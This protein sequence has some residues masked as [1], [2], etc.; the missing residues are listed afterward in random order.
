MSGSPTPS[1][2]LPERQIPNPGIG[3]PSGGPVQDLMALWKALAPSIDIIGPDIYSDDSAFY[4]EILKIY[5]RPDNALWIPETGNG[6]SYARF[7][8]YALGQ[9]AI[10]FSPFGVDHTGWTF[11]SDSGP[12]LHTENFALLAPMAREIAKLNFEGKLKTAVEE[13]VRPRRSS[14]SARGKPR[15]RSAS[16]STT[17]DAAWDP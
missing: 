12:K 8:F 13:P 16:R 14:T 5:D 17:A 10:G 6:D 7:F 15:L 4:R 3:Y 2:E 11:S 1:H 9:G